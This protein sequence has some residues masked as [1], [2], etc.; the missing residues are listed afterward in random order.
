VAGRSGRIASEYVGAARLTGAAHESPGT[1]K[2]LLRISHS[3]GDASVSNVYVRAHLAVKGDDAGKP[4]RASDDPI[5]EAPVHCRLGPTR[6]A[7]R[8][9]SP[10]A[11]VA[12]GSYQIHW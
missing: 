7:R 5:T 2:L 9:I 6:R 1:L 10:N 11:Q 3:P 12:D 4:S 8:W